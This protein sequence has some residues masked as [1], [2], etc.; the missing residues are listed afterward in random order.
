MKL[1]NSFRLLWESIKTSRQSMWVS[2]QVL[3]V[4]T[5]ILA[6]VFWIAESS[7][8]PEEFGFWNSLS[9]TFTRYIQDPGEVFSVGPATV[10]GKIVGSLLG[11]I[12]IF[13][14]AVPAGIIGGAF[15]S[16]IDDDIRKKHL[17]EMGERLEKA[18]RRKQDSQTMYKCVPRYISLG[19]LQSIKNMTQN[20]IVDAV[21][22]NPT[23][24]LRNLATAEVQ[25]TH[26]LDQ[27]V[28]EMFPKNTIYGCC[29]DRG[30]DITI[31][32]PTGVS[33]AG[34]GNFAYYMALIGGFNFISKE[35]EH[36][37]DEPVSFYI[38]PETAPTPEMEAYLADLRRLSLAN[39]S[40]QA[41][42]HDAASARALPGSSSNRWTIFLIS[43]E[44]R[45]ES[46]L[47]FVTKAN[48]NTNR[49]STLVDTEGFDRFYETF[50]RELKEEF[51][52]TADLN[53]LRP[54]GPKN[55]AVRIGGGVETN[56]FTLRIASE[57]VVWDPRYI[58]V[59]NLMA[60]DLAMT[61]GDSYAEKTTPASILKASGYGYQ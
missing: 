6:V 35:V 31:V 7:V 57:L 44:R 56:A 52:L 47:H 1:T 23:F 8:Q 18:F 29:I 41:E 15:N 12:A 9:W 19:T 30:S 51:D 10:T 28:V 5:L 27:L 45:K 37:I 3:I 14:F 59:A 2:T 4:I 42:Q 24:R 60:Q 13:L 21:E 61:L 17:T 43:S 50:S 40:T 16:A 20:D 48:A 58:A 32:C 22:C 26:P 53:E 25:G 36:N 33:E 55:V 46:H 39:P 34:I 49:T 11:I 54:A 38:I